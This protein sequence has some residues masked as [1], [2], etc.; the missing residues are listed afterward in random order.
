MRRGI[1][2]L[3]LAA[4]LGAWGMACS[5][6]VPTPAPP[7]PTTTLSRRV[8]QPMG[9]EAVQG[10]WGVAACGGEREAGFAWT[11]CTLQGDG[12]AGFL[13]SAAPQ[14]TPIDVQGHSLRMWVRVDDPVRLGG[15]ELRLASHGFEK[16]FAAAAVPLFDDPFF[17]MI[18]PGV[19]TPLSFSLGSLRTEGTVDLAAIREV[20]LYVGVRGER[21]LAFDWSG[22]DAVE[23]A[24]QGYLSITFDDGTEA[25]E[26]I[27]APAM[28]KHGFRGTAYVMP[29]EVGGDRFVSQAQ[30]AS[31]REAYGWDVAAHHGTPFTDFDGP[32]LESVILGVQGYLRERGY[33]QGAGHLAY[34]LGR[35]EPGVV[36]PLVRKHFTTARIAGGGTETIPVADRHLL[37]A[38]NVLN[39]TTPAEIGEIARR[40]KE[41]GDW[42]I[43]MFHL[44]EEEPELEISYGIDDFAKALEEI[45]ASGIEVRPVSEVWSEIQG[46]QVRAPDWQRAPAAHD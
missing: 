1:R 39:T 6:V 25:H 22:L 4:W 38:V 24:P 32:G 27:A 41:H 11:A 44:L 40:A 16:G 12:A 3:A 43:L 7:A 33:E 2:G 21:P 13:A 17:N 10:R 31:L 35:Q 46:L 36:R 29:D 15:L 14:P 18:Q 45:A 9:A 34:P 8:V 37:R 42:A 26:T 30:L 5:E 23:R 28:A 20:G 19:W